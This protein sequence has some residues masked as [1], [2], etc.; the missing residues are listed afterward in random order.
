MEVKD[1]WSSQLQSVMLQESVHYLLMSVIQRK[2]QDR[3]SILYVMRLI[4]PLAN[5][6]SVRKLPG[7][8]INLWEFLWGI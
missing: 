3:L 6:C 7:P 1:H 8:S 4:N 5:T 2:L